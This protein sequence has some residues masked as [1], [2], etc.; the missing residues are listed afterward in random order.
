MDATIYTLLKQYYGYSEFRLKQEAIIQTVLQRVDC[1]GVMPTGAGKSICYQIPSLLFTGV[2]I[3][4][5]PLISLM[6]DQVNSMLEKGISAVFLNSTLTLPQ[7]HQIIQRIE[8]GEIKLVYVAPERL[9]S[10]SFQEVLNRLVERNFLK[11]F[12]IDEAHCISEWGCEFRPDYRKLGQLKK[13]YPN[14]P[15]LALTATANIRVRTDICKQL[16]FGTDAQ[17]FVSSFD[18]PNLSYQ[19]K[20]RTLAT[21]YEELDKNGQQSA[22]VYCYKRE[23]VEQIV[24]LLKQRHMNVAGYHAGLD[25][26]SRM[27]AQKQFLSGE[28][29]IIVATVAFGMG[30][31]KLDIRL[32]IHYS[33]PKSIENYYQETG[34]AGRDGLSARCI[35][36]YS[37]SDVTRQVTVS[38]K[39][40]VSHLR[41]IKEM[42][43]YAVSEKCRRLLLLKYFD[44][45]QPSQTC[46][47]CDNCEQLNNNSSH[48]ANVEINQTENQIMWTIHLTGAKFGMSYLQNVLLGKN[49]KKIRDNNHQ[50]LEVFGL[51]SHSDANQIAQIVYHLI[52]REL[53][54]N[55][56][57][58]SQQSRMSFSIIKLTHRGYDYLQ[59]HPLITESSSQSTET[60]LSIRQ[61]MSTNIQQPS[62]SKISS[63]VN[64]VGSATD[65]ETDADAETDKKAGLSVSDLSSTK[66]TQLDEV[67]KGLKEL[68][69]NLDSDQITW[70]IEQLTSFRKLLLSY[71]N[72]KSNS[73]SNDSVLHDQL[74]AL[75]NEWRQAEN[76]PAF[77]VFPNK[78]LD[79]LIEKKPLT[80][81]EL[82]KING[83]GPQKAEKYGEGIINFFQTKLHPS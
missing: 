72:K 68:A 28:I 63:S 61:S 23:T 15:I 14:V 54:Q 22:I 53:V 58:M 35:L 32:V 33:L 57:K 65:A 69:E 76:V 12:A 9:Q 37:S 10:A 19:V 74:R 36:L 27:L 40:E 49:I 67:K 30:I 4:V 59:N 62:L 29:P 6:H 13:E 26:N 82:L 78:V 39:Y 1:L 8:K 2:T 3:V 17:I 66:N 47:N 25:A 31:N 60:A 38:D 80:L 75:R 52:N 71:Q 83:I 11:L 51:L 70:A 21:L 24:K 18:R 45:G 44:E 81:N 16:G 42:N 79:E 41:R 50:T 20:P 34:R 5:S 48:P 7:S 56:I 64:N 43:D 73:F 55:Q 46:S 77:M